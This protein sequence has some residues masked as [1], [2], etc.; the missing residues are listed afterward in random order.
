MADTAPSAPVTR[1]VG[2]LVPTNSKLLIAL[3]IMSCLVNSMTMGYDGNMMNG[4]NILPSFYNTISLN[5]S[6]QSVNTGII[7][8]GSCVAALF[9]GQVIDRWGR[10]AGMAVAALIA[11][12]GIPL[13]AAAQ[14]PAMFVV[15]RFI[16]GVGIGL[17]SVACPTYCAETAPLEW[18]AFCLGL[19]YAFWYGGG[20]LAAG[21]TYGTAKIM[22]SW[23]W[24]LPSLIQVVPAL[25]CLVVLPFI[26]ESPR[27]LMYHGRQE[28]A[29]EVLAIM[30][31]NGDKSD[32]VVV[33]QY[34]QIYDTVT[35]EQTNKAS[36]NWMDAFR[37]RN[38]RRRIMLACSC[39]II[40][41]MSGSGIISYYLGT[42]LSQAGIT[43]TNTQLQINIY[44]SI[45]CLC[46]A[47]CGTWF[48]DKIGRKKLGAGSMAVSLVFL[49]L[50]GGLTKVYGSGENYSGV[51][52]TVACIFL[53]QGTY[54][55]GWTTLL[56][57][58]PPEVLNF[59]L[60]ANGVS[61]YTFFSNG[62]A[63]IVTFAFPF[64]LA[65]I[66]WKTYMINA[67]WD[68]LEVIFIIWF[69]VE[70]SNKTLEEIDEVLD[71]EM[72]SDA[73]VLIAVMHGDV[74]VDTSLKVHG[75][76]DGKE[77]TTSKQATVT[78]T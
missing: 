34:K 47:T 74:E 29:L 49:Y 46:T 48:A 65:K 30:G 58:Y 3:V 64:A 56:V 26:P 63:C 36:Q 43:D 19:Y 70:T 66:G 9:S 33:T 7:W 73:P 55:F 77:D 78:V 38:N 10:K 17:S 20:L 52:G 75:H 76:I 24:R 53:Y 42:M 11:F 67:T 45:W 72:H 41:N 15:S 37:T 32:P 51:L 68:V 2:K 22:S 40:G 44:L 69:W 39:A 4:L 54:S 18:R 27:W 23:A 31:A 50:V 12:V 71:G 14:N 59:S 28:E 62:A 8:V 21:V 1:H 5:T 35:F 25:L 60:R 57:M 61:I 13:Q 16:V 6:G